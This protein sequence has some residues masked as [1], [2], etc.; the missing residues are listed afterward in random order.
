MTDLS[1]ALRQVHREL[2]PAI[3]HARIAVKTGRREAEF[4]GE[5]LKL[6][7]QAHELREEG[8]AADCTGPLWELMQ[9]IP[10]NPGFVGLNATEKFRR[11]WHI[12]QS[13][14]PRAM[15]A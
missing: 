14:S 5:Y 10:I 4:V 2:T 6:V 1:D 7:R 8:I 13:P 12:E 3:H 9:P 15:A 11:E